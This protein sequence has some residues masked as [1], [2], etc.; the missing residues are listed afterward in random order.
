MMTDAQL[1]TIVEDT[2][3]SFRRAAA[4]LL[5]SGVVVAMAT[6]AVAQAELIES[7]PPEL[8]G[9]SPRDG[10]FLAEPQLIMLA[11]TKPVTLAKN[12]ITVTGGNGASW[13]LGEPKV[14]GPL[15]TAPVRARGPLGPYTINYQLVSEDGDEFSGSV[16]FTLISPDI[17]TITRQP[18]SGAAPPNG[19]AST[20]PTVGPH[21]QTHVLPGAVSDA[22]STNDS[23]GIPAWVWILGAIVVLAIGLL[24]AFRV[25][26]SRRS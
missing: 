23:P 3:M 26:R 14:N 13:T 4:A 19:A 7:S 16:P 11:F 24:E 1:R 22:S 9:S 12:P 21:G 17:P 15:V 2:A 8:I 25:G 10:A 6:P 5:L 18:S 20:A